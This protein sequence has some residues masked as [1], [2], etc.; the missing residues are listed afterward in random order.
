MALKA[1]KNNITALENGEALAIVTGQ[2]PAYGLGPLYTLVK[3]AQCVATCRQLQAAGTPAVPIFWCASEDHDRGEADHADLLHAN[4]SI[5]RLHM[6]WTTDGASSHYQQASAGY[7]TLLNACATLPWSARSRMAAEHRPQAN[8]N[9]GAW[10]ARVIQQLF[11][12]DG[13]IIVEPYA[14][15]P[16]W[17]SQAE[18]WHKTG[19][20]CGWLS[21]ITR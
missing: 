12:D 15:R 16:H 14:L 20:C 2:Q 11:A 13:L 10:V 4:G 6:P 18:H 5:E 3:I 8:E 17:G 7:E 21:D 9:L 1:T 19:R